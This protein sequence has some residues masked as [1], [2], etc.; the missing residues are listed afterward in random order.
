MPT[1]SASRSPGASFREALRLESPPQVIGGINANHALLAQR[2]GF[3]AIYLSGDGVAAA[4]AHDLA[5]RV[6]FR[7]QQ[8]A[9]CAPPTK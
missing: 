5:P 7:A 6:V 4:I 9:K 2:A 1:P 3:R 8:C